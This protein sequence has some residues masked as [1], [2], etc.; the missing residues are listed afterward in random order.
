M[1][2]QDSIKKQVI[3]VCWQRED[4]ESSQTF[5]AAKYNVVD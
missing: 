2:S 5:K 4:S 3:E 1:I